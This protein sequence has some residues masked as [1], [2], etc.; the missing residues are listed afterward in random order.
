MTEQR[1]GNY[2]VVRKLGEGAMGIVFEAI[3]DEI[4]KRAAIKILH[5]NFSR[6]PQVSARFL[7]EARIVNM[8][9]HPGLVSIFEFGRNPDGATYLVM[10]FLRGETLRDRI[11]RQGRIPVAEAQSIVRQVADALAAAHEQNIVHRDLKPENLMLV[12][13]PDLAGGLRTKILDFGV[14]KVAQQSAAAMTQ[15]GAVLGTA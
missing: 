7:N 8:V 2:R 3:H 15:A 12:P 4:G 6:D 14:A 11:E 9:Q 13:D 5:S 10:E 1:F